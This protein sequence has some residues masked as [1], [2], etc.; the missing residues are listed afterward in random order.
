MQSPT[1]SLI[2]R[3]LERTRGFKLLMCNLNLVLAIKL[4]NG[5]H[6]CYICELELKPHYYVL[7]AE[8]GP[9]LVGRVTEVMCNHYY[10]H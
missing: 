6:K 3:F 8:N 4:Q 10:H 9:K 7:R 1:Y 5:S 2:P